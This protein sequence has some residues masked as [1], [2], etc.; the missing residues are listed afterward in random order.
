[1][2]EQIYDYI[3]YLTY[4]KRENHLLF[5]SIPS[6]LPGKIKSSYRGI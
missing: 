6:P 1:M 5:R 4:E 3:E 2:K